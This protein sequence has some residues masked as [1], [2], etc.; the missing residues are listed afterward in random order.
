M[1][2]SK[3]R[4]QR[5]L[6]LKCGFEIDQP[7]G[8]NGFL[9]CPKGHRVQILK[10]RPLWAIGPVSFAISFWI[11]SVIIHL[12]QTIWLSDSTRPIIW[13][14][15]AVASAS[16]IYLAIQGWWLLSRPE[17]IGLIA[18]QHI[19]VGLGRIVAAIVLG[20]FARMRISY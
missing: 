19:A 11:L 14:V 12:F 10:S 1:E 16:G 6:C 17:P 2:N 18:R 8:K 5:F 20:V 13:S 4:K 3:V 15:L 7:E 9:R